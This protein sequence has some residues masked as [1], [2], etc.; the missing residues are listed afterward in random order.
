MLPSVRAFFA[1]ILDYAGLFPPAQLPLDEAIRNYARYRTEPESWLLGRFVC[2]ANLLPEVLAN[3]GPCSLA[4]V[5]SGAC[6]NLGVL[7]SL[8]RYSATLETRG[9]PRQ[10]WSELP[11]FWEFEPGAGM[12]AGEFVSLLAKTH[13][14]DGFKLRCGGA[15]ASVVPSV[16]QVA[17]VVAT[18]RDAGVPLKFT[19]GLHHPLRHYDNGLQT[20]LH[21]FLNVFAAGVLG[22]ARKLNE[23][24]LCEI[25]AD[26]DAGHFRFA[27]GGF[28]WKDHCATV[29]EIAA[30]R[31][32]G[33]ISFGSCS[34]EEPRDDLRRMGLL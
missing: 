22:H 27:D 15:N 34:F 33:I 11:T 2:P 23:E 20:K 14:R 10:P 7:Q 24:Q 29:D 9:A 13:R 32:H 19:A 30:A 21:G 31:Q 4:I 12:A 6:D 25:V 16:E 5:V 17:N 3:G 1:G 26:E 28:A 18:C 8:Q